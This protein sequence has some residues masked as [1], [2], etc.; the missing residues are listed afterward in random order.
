MIEVKN[1]RQRVGIKKKQQLK[2]QIVFLNA[3]AVL[4]TDGWTFRLCDGSHNHEGSLG[5][6]HLNP[7]KGS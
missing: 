2:K 1:I 3:L 5:G 7:S 6:A 4:Q